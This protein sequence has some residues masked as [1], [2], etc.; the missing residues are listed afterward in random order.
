VGR[1]LQDGLAPTVRDRPAGLAWL[2]QWPLGRPNVAWSQRAVS[3]TPNVLWHAG[4]HTRQRRD[5]AGDDSP[6]WGCGA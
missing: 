2:A 5:V 1:K 4:A 3:V 6:A